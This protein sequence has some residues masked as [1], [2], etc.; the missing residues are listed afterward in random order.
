LLG[1][2]SVKLHKDLGSNPGKHFT[3]GIEPRKVV[4]IGFPG[5]SKGFTGPLNERSI[6]A[7][8]VKEYNDW[9]NAHVD[10]VRQYGLPPKFEA[11]SPRKKSL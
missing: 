5:S 9:A 11:A 3:N 4:V 8:S 6:H 10:A 1:E 7:Y 2:A